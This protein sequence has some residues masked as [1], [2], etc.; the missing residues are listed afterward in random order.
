MADRRVGVRA[1]C[2][3]LLM[4]LSSVAVLDKVFDLGVQKNEYQ[5]HGWSAMWRCH[6]LK[7][8]AA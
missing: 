6:V 8:C 3:V 7:F 2:V 1:L 4:T 5:S